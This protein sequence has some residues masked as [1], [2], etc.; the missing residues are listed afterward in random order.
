MKWTI[1]SILWLIGLVI[2]PLLGLLD[3][4]GIF[5]ME[6]P[7]WLILLLGLLVGY[8]NITKGESMGFLL[9]GIALTLTAT[10][11]A[12]LPMVGAAVTQAATNLAAVIGPAMLLVA[13]KVIMKKG[14]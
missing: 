4:L 11:L 3:G 10:S 14:K 12:L 13:A 9:A 8:M 7:I 6:L 2:V 5:A 1:N